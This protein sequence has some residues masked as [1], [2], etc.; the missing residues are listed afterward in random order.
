MFDTLLLL[1][2]QDVIDPTTIG[3]K[4]GQAQDVQQVLGVIVGVL[5]L[6]VLAVVGWYLRERK[7]CGEEKVDIVKRWGEAKLAWEVERG[8][9]AGQLAE[10]AA[11][12]AEDKEGLMRELIDLSLRIEKALARLA[13]LAAARGTQP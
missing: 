8:K 4:L 13:D 11:A 12:A 3:E 10:L 9:H 6:V 5:V 7:A 2:A 1:F